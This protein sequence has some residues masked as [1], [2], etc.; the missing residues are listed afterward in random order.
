MNWIVATF[1]LM[2]VL[3]A[4]LPLVVSLAYTWVTNPETQSTE[5]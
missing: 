2:F 1:M 5:E 3:V 4:F